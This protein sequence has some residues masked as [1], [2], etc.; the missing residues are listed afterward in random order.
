MA[1]LA[2]E[3]LGLLFHFDPLYLMG[4]ENR[5]GVGLLTL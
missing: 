5:I 3:A 4:F 2:Q 1:P